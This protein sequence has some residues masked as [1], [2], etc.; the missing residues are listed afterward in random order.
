MLVDFGEFIVHVYD[1]ETR[2]YYE[3]ERLWGDAPRLDAGL[4]EREAVAEG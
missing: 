3:L 2:A 1:S 4:A